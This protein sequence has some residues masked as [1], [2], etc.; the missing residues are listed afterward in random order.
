M[1]GNVWEWCLDEYDSDFYATFPPNDVVRNPVAGPNSVV[2]LLRKLINMKGTRLLRG[3]AWY[4]PEIEVRVAYRIY[5][6]PSAMAGFVGFRC[7][8]DVTP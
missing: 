2:R 4:S 7:V 3:G 1:A 5:N 8:K 6:S